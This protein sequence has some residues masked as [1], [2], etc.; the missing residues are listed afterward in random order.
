MIR[1]FQYLI[2]FTS[3]PSVLPEQNDPY[4]I[5]PWKVN[6]TKAYKKWRTVNQSL[7]TIR[8]LSKFWQT[9][10]TAWKIPLTFRQKP[11]CRE[12]GEKMRENCFVNKANMMNY[13]LYT[14]RIS[15]FFFLHFHTFIVVICTK[16]MCIGDKR[17]V[18]W[19]QIL[20]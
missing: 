4:R 11:L 10:D 3:A 7:Y 16:W 9:S 14:V 1:N 5:Q 15:H 18:L 20:N 19:W 17:V 13:F 8:S 2:V 6:E 12:N